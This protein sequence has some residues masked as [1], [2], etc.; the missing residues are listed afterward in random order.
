LPIS[1]NVG[2]AYIIDGDLYV[3]DG[4][5]WENVGPIVGPTGANLI[6][7]NTAPSG[8]ISP[9][10]L[11]CDSET[12]KTYIYFNDLDSFQWVEL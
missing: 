12:G 11:W 5:S 2:D 7:S 8:T 1:G 4:T 6:I 9:G 10:S 3:W